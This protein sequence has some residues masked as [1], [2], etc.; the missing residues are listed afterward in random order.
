MT[1]PIDL[2]LDDNGH[3]V[4]PPMVDLLHRDRKSSSFVITFIPEDNV[5]KHEKETTVIS[6]NSVDG[7]MITTLLKAIEAIKGKSI[8]RIFH[9]GD[10]DFGFESEDRQGWSLSD[11]GST[12]E[13]SQRVC[14]YLK[15][16]GELAQIA[17]LQNKSRTA[18]AG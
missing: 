18:R 3:L 17:Y 1:N 10:G 14:D 8:E 15:K 5:S 7:R 4:D 6:E 2:P 9:R 12:N 11:E 13:I 16:I